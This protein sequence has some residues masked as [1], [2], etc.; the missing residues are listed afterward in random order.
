MHINY[1][2]KNS[3]SLSFCF[4]SNMYCS[5][6][7]GFGLNLISSIFF[8]FG[9]HY[10]KQQQFN[11]LSRDI[12]IIKWS[13]KKK[14]YGTRNLWPFFF[15]IQCQF[16]SMFL[17]LRPNQFVDNSTNSFQFLSALCVCMCVWE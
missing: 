13:A 15:I 9:W 14:T 2:S 11:F 6:V 17:H 7:F 1:N 8:V 4:A 5:Y 16:A 10:K 12:S 3:Y